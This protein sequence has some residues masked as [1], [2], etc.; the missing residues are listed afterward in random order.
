[1]SNVKVLDSLPEHWRGTTTIEAT[2][3]K[4]FSSVCFLE[5]FDRGLCSGTLCH[6]E[7]FFGIENGIIC[8]SPLL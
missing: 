4:L 3:T 2:I 6:E 5:D 7:L 1:M 8:F